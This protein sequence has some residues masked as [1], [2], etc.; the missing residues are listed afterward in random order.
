MTVR[1]EPSVAHGTFTVERRYDASP[2]RVF[3]AHADP[4]AFRRWFADGEEWTVH[5]WEQDFRVGGHFRGS[6]RFGDENNATWFNETEYLDIVE[7]RRMVWSYVMGR[8]SPDGRIR[9]SV[10][11]ATTEIVADGAG[12][13]LVYTEQ[14][15]FL[16]SADD[17]ALRERGC[18]DMLDALGRELKAHA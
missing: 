7:N 3:A 2:A 8:E 13:R 18:A 17:I 5:T 12:T 1:T 11:L 6:F 15:A 10:S 14:G 4:A 9:N 16:E